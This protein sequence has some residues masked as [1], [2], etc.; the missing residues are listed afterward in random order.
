MFELTLSSGQNKKGLKQNHT[1][2]SL[3]QATYISSGKV[4]DLFT[5]DV[6]YGYV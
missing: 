5:A 1:E 2:F 6:G 3:E 4:V